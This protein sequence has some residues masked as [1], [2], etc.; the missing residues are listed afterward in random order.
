[1]RKFTFMLRRTL[2]GMMQLR[3][4]QTKH[5]GLTPTRGRRERRAEHRS[6][7]NTGEHRQNRG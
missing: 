6:M 1:M 5:A 4:S 2:N 7:S 3:N